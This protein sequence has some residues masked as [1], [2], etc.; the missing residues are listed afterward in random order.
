M[1]VTSREVGRDPVA[2]LQQHEVTDD[3]VDGVDL[4]PR[5]VPDHG[6]PVR[7]QVPQ[8]SR[9]LVGA[10]LLDERE[11]AVEHHD[12]GDGDGQ[13]RHPGHGRQSGGHPQQQREE[14]H[15][16]PAAARR[17]ATAAAA[18]GSSFGPSRCSRSAASAEDS[19]RAA[20]AVVL[21][22]P[23]VTSRPPSDPLSRA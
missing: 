7:D 20:E 5:A 16:L 21:V 19:P 10:L 23:G 11:H 14:V 9:G 3:E 12:D 13:L 17:S 15:E 4:L 6:H 18:V 8:A 22:L 2:G 1:H